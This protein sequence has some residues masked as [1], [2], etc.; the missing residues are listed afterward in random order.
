MSPGW[1]KTQSVEWD[2]ASNY[3]ASSKKE[4]R[5]LRESS[6]A[7]GFHFLRHNFISEFPRRFA[8]R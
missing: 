1:W 8:L 2:M 4:K 5:Q 6:F 3:S 7:E